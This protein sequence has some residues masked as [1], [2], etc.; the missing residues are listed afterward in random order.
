MNSADIAYGLL[1][2]LYVVMA[3]AAASHALLH[4]RDPRSAWGW[5]IACWLFP[6]GGALMYWWFGINRVQRRARRE[7]G[8][9]PDVHIARMPTAFP[10][11][12][13]ATAQ[14]VGE[15]VRTGGAMTGRDLL[16]GNRV[17]P[18]HNGEQAYPAMLEA[19]AAA[20]NTVWISSYIFAGDETGR[21]FAQALEQAQ[22]RGVEVRV[23]V[24]GVG[25]LL[26]RPRGEPLL[27]QHSV[28]VERFFPPR[29]FP[30]M[31]HINLRNHRKLMIV[32]GGCAFVGGMN[33]GDHHFARGAHR[34]PN[35][36]MQFRVEGPVATQL[37]QV[38]ADD[39][40]Q[41]TEEALQTPTEAAANPGG[42]WCRAITD[43]PNDRVD[44]LQMVL[45][46]ALASAHRSVRIMTPYFS[47]T[48]DLVGALQSAALRGI[49]VCII[50]PERSDQP[51]MDAAAR[52]WVALML[53]YPLRIFYQPSPFA[54]T[55][56]LLVDDYYAQVG[57]AN[58]DVRSLRLNFELMME[59]YDVALAGTLC[60]HF[61]EIRRRSRE[62]IPQTLHD[63]PLP[64]RLLDA[65]CWLFSPYL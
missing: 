24:D 30:P 6:L 44:R 32:D 33:I 3:L 9:V 41:C 5:I 17:T 12:A 13:G 49:E 48:A 53:E 10:G 35:A 58:L 40:Q 52:R 57:S 64:R 47:P 54:H 16:G 26:W 62:V 19:I 15:L 42:A 59:A 14:E 29:L 31:L 28:R 8:P 63:R 20:R 34:L 7:F 60:G 46:A 56:L 21:R 4:K 38:F 27:R 50:L 18:L 11:F 23:L 22:Q 36:D 1:S 61:D 51:W 25:E 65:V 39:W 2:G 43:G 55:K 45:L 37:A